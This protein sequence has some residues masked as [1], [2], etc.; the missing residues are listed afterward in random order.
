MERYRD[1]RQAGG[2]LARLLEHHGGSR[3]LVVSP[4]GGGVVVAAEVAAAL[5]GALGV[6]VA[7]PFGPPGDLDFSIGAVTADGGAVVAED[8]AARLGLARED[9]A[10]AIAAAAAEAR[11]RE[12]ALR[13]G[14]ALEPAGR[15]VVVV[16]DGVAGGATLRAVLGRMRR[17]GPRFLGCAVPVGLPATV[18]L[19]ASEVDEIICPLQPLRFHSVGEWYQDFPAVGDDEV[20]A[21]LAAHLR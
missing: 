16:D 11:R 13:A 14:R 2:E 12:R 4:A 9:L 21:L 7:V 19:I 20:A 15:T 17:A 10:P 6:V 3:P 18:D 5:D 8:L 1:R